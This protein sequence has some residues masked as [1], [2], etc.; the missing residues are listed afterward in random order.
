V[1]I[2]TQRAPLALQRC[3]WYWK[4]V[5]LFVHDPFCAV[6]VSPTRAVPVIVGAA[7]FAGG[8]ADALA[9]VAS[10][11]SAATRGTPQR[12]RFTFC[13]RMFDSPFIDK[14][15]CARL[16]HAKNASIEGFTKCKQEVER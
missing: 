15:I 7:V 6:S 14:G 2:L 1:P 12:E 4:A 5:G 13:F 11:R 9:V 10:A 16:Q 8:A 3:H